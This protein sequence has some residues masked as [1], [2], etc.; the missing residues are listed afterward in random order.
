MHQKRKN[1]VVVSF[2]KKLPVKVFGYIKAFHFVD[3]RYKLAP[4]YVMS[5]IKHLY[6]G[7]QKSI[8]KNI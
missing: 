1:E 2:T 6:E 8:K 4:K 5:N 7:N 3:T